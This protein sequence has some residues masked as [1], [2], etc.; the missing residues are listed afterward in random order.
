MVLKVATS[1]LALPFAVLVGTQATTVC[2][3]A[4]S[5]AQRLCTPSTARPPSRSDL[6][7]GQRAGVETENSTFSPVLRR[8]WLPHLATLIVADTTL[9]ST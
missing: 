9:R 8:C 3:C 6:P 2:L 5:V 7:Q 4:S 1:R